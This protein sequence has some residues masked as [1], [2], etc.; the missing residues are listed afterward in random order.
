MGEIISRI[1]KKGLRISHGVLS[2]ISKELAERH[3]QEHIG[4]PFYDEL[5]GF[6]TSGPSFVAIV[7]GPNQTWKILRSLMGS[8][9][10]L[11]A[12]MGTI[13]GD[14]ATEI[15]QNLVH[16]SDSEQAAVREIKLFF[17]DVQLDK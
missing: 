12:P 4:K 14:L 15:G 17:P 16:G 7:E 2:T 10:P 1:E 6:I 13:R 9:D 11:D 3:Y 8:T 5:V